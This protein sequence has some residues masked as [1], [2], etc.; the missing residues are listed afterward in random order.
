MGDEGGPSVK[1]LLGQ[2]LQLARQHESSLESLNGRM[3]SIEEQNEDMIDKM[4]DVQEKLHGGNSRSSMRDMPCMPMGGGR[5]PPRRGSTS[6]GVI[7]TPQSY[8]Q[9]RRG[10]YV[11]ALTSGPSAGPRVRSIVPTFADTLE[12]EEEEEEEPAPAAAPEPQRVVL[13]D[14]VHQVEGGG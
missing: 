11:D 4:R 10:T 9:N 12:E 7:G 5:L 6:N 3:E 14:K 8:L 1:D 13:E 2:L